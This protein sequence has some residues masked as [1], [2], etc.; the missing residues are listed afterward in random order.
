MLCGQNAFSLLP[1]RP[2]SVHLTHSL[3]VSFIEPEGNKAQTLLVARN[4]WANGHQLLNAWGFAWF[5]TIT[6]TASATI[7][8]TS[9]F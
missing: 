2:S 3:C 5:L 6:E 9:S 4:N 1:G 7:I 8:G